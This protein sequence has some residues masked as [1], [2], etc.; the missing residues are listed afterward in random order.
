VL[1][2]L[3][4]GITKEELLDFATAYHEHLFTGHEDEFN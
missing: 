1:R 3:L 2:E 4:E